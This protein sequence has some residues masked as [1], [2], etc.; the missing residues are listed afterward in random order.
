MGED[1]VARTMHQY[2]EAL[3]AVHPASVARGQNCHFSENKKKT[4]VHR[5]LS[6]DALTNYVVLKRILSVV[7]RV[8]ARLANAVGL[9]R[10]KNQNL[11][12]LSIL[13]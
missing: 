1:Y 3:L 9:P 10:Q 5:E 11:D 8:H 12:A 6:S 13:P 2:V 4:S 7:A